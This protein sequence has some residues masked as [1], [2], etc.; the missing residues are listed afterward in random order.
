MKNYLLHSDGM[1]YS[2]ACFFSPTEYY[3]EY[4]YEAGPEIELEDNTVY[5]GI[6]SI[7]LHL[8]LD[9]EHYGLP[10]WN[11]LGEYILPGQNVLIKPNFVMHKNGSSNPEDMESL[12][13]HASVIRSVIDY[14][15]LALKGKG[16]LVIADSPVKDCDFALLMKN[17]G[18]DKL[19]EFYRRVNAKPMPQFVDLRGPGEEGGQFH[20]AGE[21]II[22]D[23]GMKSFFYNSGH[24]SKKLR[25]PNYDYRKVANHHYGKKQE[26]MVN[27]IV[28][29]ADVIISLPKPKTHRKTGYTGAL[30]NFVGVNYSKEYLPHHT[31]GDIASGGDEYKESNRYRDK[32][33]KLRDKID[34]NRTQID[35]LN[36]KILCC[37]TC[38]SRL[39]LRG[40]R[41]SIYK[42]YQ[43]RWS[44]WKDLS[45]LDD[46]YTMTLSGTFDD[47]AREGTW[48]G[49]DTLW[50]SVLDLNLVVQYADKNGIVQDVPQRKILC[51]G[52]MV[53]VGEGEGPLSP[54]PKQINTLLFSENPVEFDA[55]LTKI[56]GFDW[57]KLRVLEHSIKKSALF[58]GKYD[59]IIINSNE[60][61]YNGKLV[62]VS[63][64]DYAPF[65]PAKGWK[66]FV[67]LA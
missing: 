25:I 46:E 43:R 11:P 19:I 65:E 4:Q 9:A 18:Y 50:R 60:T 13:T 28:L 62:D 48:H 34:I 2:T 40:M 63:F 51:L 10:S 66:G 55:I 6:R 32:Q 35:K 42:L 20:Q 3:P 27:S 39:L 58:S 12:V 33:S 38:S 16:S 29:D 36:R 15:L 37:R 8:G 14:C 54:T 24:D 45:R 22:V 41:K 23:L 21:G 61:V 44:V 49:N 53:I 64:Q 47:L 30:K 57:T 17:A 59:D 67:E 5:S 52:D 1:K 7:F 56:M 26:Y 31:A